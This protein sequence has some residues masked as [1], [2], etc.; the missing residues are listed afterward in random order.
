MIVDNL[1]NFEKFGIYKITNLKNNKIYVGSTGRSFKDRFNEHSRDLKNGKHKNYYLQSSYNKWG[2]NIFKFE[3]LEIINNLEF[4][5]DREQKYLDDLCISKKF[6]YNINIKATGGYQFSEEVY[7]KRAQSFKETLNISINYSKKIKNNEITVDDV[8][9]KYKKLAIYY[10]TPRDSSKNRTKENGYTFDHLKVPKTIS[11][12]LKKARKIS[13]IKTRENRT[14]Y[15]EVYD[16]FGKYINTFR[17]SIDIQEYSI[18]YPKYFPILDRNTNSRTGDISYLKV[19][20]ITNCC[21]NRVKH[22]KG[23]QFK[24]AGDNKKILF[25]TIHDINP[26]INVNTKQRQ[27]N[28]MYYRYS[29]L[30]EQSNMKHSLNSVKALEE[31]NTE[32][33]IVLTNNEGVT[34]R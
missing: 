25:L 6:S 12:E 8:P 14:P 2:E 15:I 34:T 29:R 32:P 31:S 3:I 11:E 13:S 17:S 23:L 20:N 30:L 22:Y 7:K 16:T 27:K 24:Y 21:N 19:Q 33:S 10:I 18:K 26:K 9:K 4:L 1:D 28:N 5:H